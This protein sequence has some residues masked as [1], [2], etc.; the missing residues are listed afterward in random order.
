MHKFILLFPFS[1]VISIVLVCF[2]TSCN[3]RPE[4]KTEIN[5]SGDTINQELNRLTNAILKNPGNIES[6]LVRAEYYLKKEM[7]NEALQDVNKALT[8]DEKDAR[9]YTTLSDIY[10]LSGKTQQ[11]LDA[12]RKAA[13]LDPDNAD[14][15]VKTARLFLTMSDYKQTFNYLRS[16]LK[17]NPT[18]SEAFFISGLANEEMGDTTKAIDGYQMA[19]AHNQKH[20]DALKQLG[21]LFSIRKDK[22]AIDYLRNAAQVRPGQP[23]PL[24]ILGMFY[25]ENGEPDKSLSV[26]NEILQIDSTYKLAWYNKGYVQL[27]YKQEYL[28]AVE[29]FT[30]ALVLDAEY[31][32]AMYNRGYAYELLGDY[33]NAAKDYNK[34]LRISE[35]NDKAIQGLNRLD[36]LK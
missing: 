20:Y 17:K 33:K 15:D 7:F 27:V 28:K 24:Y 29:S 1:I 14:I 32:E 31:A 22:L 3:R 16:A 30:K 10:L 18:N 6:Y 21:I 8:L 26:Y 25:Q 4:V 11:A 12:L 35:N 23:E 9:V 13:N 2:G 19:V 36:A 5:T 34:V